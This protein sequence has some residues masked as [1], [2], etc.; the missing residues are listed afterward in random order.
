LHEK[1]PQKRIVI[2]GDD[3]RHLEPTHGINPSA[4]KQRKLARAVGGKVILPIFPPHENS[5]PAGIEAVTPQK[6]RNGE[7]SDKHHQA[8]AKMKRYSDFNDLATKSVL[9]REAVKR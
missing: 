4:P 8:L 9:G 3:D 5:H 1:Y 7:F 6:F 2:A